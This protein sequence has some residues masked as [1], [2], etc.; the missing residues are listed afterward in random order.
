MPSLR[1][2]MSLSLTRELRAFLD[3]EAGLGCGVGP[4]TGSFQELPER[5]RA[6]AERANIPTQ[7][8]EAIEA[9]R[10][11]IRQ[12]ISEV[13][14]GEEVTFVH[15]YGNRG[16]DLIYAGARQLLAGIPYREISAR[17]KLREA[18]GH[19][20]VMS[21]GGDWCNAFHSFDPKVFQALEG[22]FENVVLLPTTFDPSVP[23]VKRIL[24]RTNATVFVRERES[25]RR[26]KNLCE[27]DIAHDTAFFFDYTPYVQ[28][29]EGLL[30]AYRAD[31]ETARAPGTESLLPPGNDDISMTCESLDEWL[32]TISR[33]EVVHTDRA[34]VMIA[35]VLMGK[36]VEYRASNYFKVPAIAEY[37]LG[38]FPI[39]RQ[40]DWPAA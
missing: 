13:S 23:L 24:K 5:C 8:A 20:A 27:A 7:A 16:D 37:S 34:H 4:R 19:T 38:S 33:H 9:S 22:R 18:G 2:L 30:N 21:G 17:K 35:A 12:K 29:G 11:K 40:P 3:V 36:R 39:H 14:G 26:I 1:S 6:R 31:P 32:W 25:Q 15:S 10:R 28:K